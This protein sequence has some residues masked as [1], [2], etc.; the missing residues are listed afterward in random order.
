MDEGS[1]TLIMPTSCWKALK[2]PTLAKSNT[3]LKAFDSHNFGPKVVFP[4]FSIELG[5]NVYVDVGFV[6][7][8]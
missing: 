5:E 4:R 7:A 3:T 8:P 2:S 6:D 1:S